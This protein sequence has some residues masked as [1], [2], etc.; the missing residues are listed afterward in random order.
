MTTQ[1][2]NMHLCD[3]P[4]EVLDLILDY[5]LPPH[6]LARQKPSDLEWL[7]YRNRDDKESKPLPSVCAVNKLLSQRALAIFYDK[8]ILE[9]VPVKPP[10]FIFEALER[11]FSFD[12]ATELGAC[13]AFCPAAH[14]RRIKRVHLFSG[15]SDVVN[16]EGYE[17]TLRWLIETTSV[18]DVH[19]S[20]LL[21][22]RLRRARMDI[23]PALNAITQEA[24]LVRT[25]Y[26]WTKHCRSYYETLRMAEM[27]R[28]KGRAPPSLQMYLYQQGN[29]M[30]PVLDPRW[31]AR[32]S[33][34]NRHHSL[35][36]PL[37]CLFDRLAGRDTICRLAKSSWK[38]PTIADPPKD[39]LYQICFIFGPA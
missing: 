33:N 15:Q 14:L 35:F 34:D 26:I 4:S 25:V 37:T 11:G 9:V 22:T 23:G 16:A 31:A 1:N 30:D 18:K 36:E 10:E 12:L 28:A 2:H 8:A 39:S 29:A 17:A 38:A 6:R 7:D 24:A 20:R 27:A 5:A 3:L 32:C 13:H 19:L 21:L